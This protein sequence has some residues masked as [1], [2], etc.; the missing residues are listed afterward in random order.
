MD[1]FTVVMMNIDLSGL[2]DFTARPY[3][4]PADHLAMAG[5]VNNWH[6]AIGLLEHATVADV[7][8]SYA[9]LNNCDPAA[10]MVMVDGPDGTL[11]GYIRVEWADVAGEP[12]RYWT[13]PHIDPAHRDTALWPR[14]AEA[15]IERN[16]VIAADHHSETGK[17]L[18]GFSDRDRAPDIGD[19]YEALGF[20]IE[21]YGA[22]MSRTLEGDLPTHRLPDGLEMRP[23]TEEQLRQIWEA[24]TEAFRDHWGWA[25]PTE[26][27]YQWFVDN[28]HRDI[29][30]WRVA[31]DG[32]EVAGQVK[33]YINH[34][35]NGVLDRRRGYTEF[36]S[37]GRRWRKQGVA[38]ALICASF[39]A[40]R[41][42]GMTEAALGVHAEN[43]TGAF[44]LYESLGFEVESMWLT[45]QRPI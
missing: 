10:D 42:A 3:A 9:H 14:L 43:P 41:D 35:E 31:W 5:L 4:G 23:V 25:E 30:L 24:D 13:V 16:L 1:R 45:W 11:A 19:R 39:E 20:D 18:E 7:N 2:A 28:P 33:S 40:L 15:A 37:T 22:S 32:D 36:I 27:D 12:T 38:S 26:N 17:V 34:E 21:T 8:N 29:S 44:H 6:E